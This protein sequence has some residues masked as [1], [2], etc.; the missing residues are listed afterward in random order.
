VAWA[1]ARFEMGCTRA[2]DAEALSDYLLA[3]RALLDAGSEAGRASLSLRLAALCAEEHERRLLQRRVE[4]ALALERYV[5]AGGRDMDYVE[6]LGSESPRMLVAEMERHLR[7][8]LRDVLCGYLD[9]NLKSVADDILLRAPASA[10]A[11]ASE[12]EPE[13]EPEPVTPAEP[14]RDPITEELE[15]VEASA[16]RARRITRPAP[17]PDDSWPPP[18]PE[19]DL[20]PARAGSLLDGVTPSADW[21]DYSAP[22]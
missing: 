6:T 8:L 4:L 7:A 9:P 22:V 13:P 16:L 17:E 20:E 5:M 11:T 21:D 1:L 12:P 14:E 10:P 2:L 3:L 18:E 19:E 15:A